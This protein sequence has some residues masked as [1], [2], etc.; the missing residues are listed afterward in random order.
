[1]KFSSILPHV[2]PGPSEEY[3]M[4]SSFKESD[5]MEF[6]VTLYSVVHVWCFHIL[7]D[8]KNSICAC[9]NRKPRLVRFYSE[10]C[11][12]CMSLSTSKGYRV[13]Q[14]AGFGWKNIKNDLKLWNCLWNIIMIIDPYVSSN[15]MV[16]EE[17]L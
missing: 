6:I 17:Q 2:K 11:I 9:C 15:K 10:D 8:K 12:M 16:T 5:S 13:L 1:M 3:R 7:E 4:S 14:E